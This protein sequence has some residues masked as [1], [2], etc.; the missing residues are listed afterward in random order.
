MRAK[1]I[2]STAPAFTIVELLVVVT[3]IT[4]LIGLLLPSLRNAR[5]TG[6][7]TKCLSNMGQTGRGLHSF[8]TDTNGILPGPSWYG[9]EPRYSSGT[10]TVARFLAPYSGFPRATSTVQVN[11]LFVC[12]SFARV[13][14]PGTTISACV[15]MGALSQVNSKGLRVFGY[16]EFEGS[17]EYGPD[18]FS[19]VANPSAAKAIRDID[20]YATPNAGWVA[21]TA[22]GPM[23]SPEASSETLRNYLYFDTHARTVREPLA[24]P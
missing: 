2:Q 13:Q 10:K 8:I 5:L 11:D 19:A 1:A 3:L 14:P 16:P 20:Q 23:H 9:Q 21:L 12:P 17:P 24:T 15:I 18:K 4:L 22:R 7:R 6:E